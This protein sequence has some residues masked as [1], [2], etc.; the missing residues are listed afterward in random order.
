ME[1]ELDRLY[2]LVSI[3]YERP[4]SELERQEYVSLFYQLRDNNIE[5]PFGV[6]I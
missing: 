6:E 3:E 4:L 1:N 2:E 5:I